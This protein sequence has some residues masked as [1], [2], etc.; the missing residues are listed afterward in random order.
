MQVSCTY[1]LLTPDVVAGVLRLSAVYTWW[2]MHVTAVTVV[3]VNG[4]LENEKKTK[5]S[6]NKYDGVIDLE[7]AVNKLIAVLLY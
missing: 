7:M 1:L 6:Y 5:K 4:K 2:L 3:F